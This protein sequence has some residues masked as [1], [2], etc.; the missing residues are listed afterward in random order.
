[1]NV[2]LNYTMEWM[3]GVWYD[4]QL[5]LQQYTIKMELITN[6]MEG[7]DH[8]VSLGRLQHF[9]YTGMQDTVYINANEQAQIAK[10]I[11]AGIKVTALPEDPTDQV[12]GIIVFHKLNAILENRMT[13]ISLDISSGGNNIWYL[14]NGNEMSGPFEVESWWGDSSPAHEITSISQKNIVKFNNKSSWKKLGLLW[15]DNTENS[16]A[17]ILE[18]HKDE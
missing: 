12:I 1:M 4:D 2:R 3:A 13:V 11:E 7:R 14:H 8:A 9:I 15:E 18:F 17:T 6:T 5:E 10:L 16:V